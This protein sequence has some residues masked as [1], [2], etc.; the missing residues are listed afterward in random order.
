MSFIAAF[1]AEAEAEAAAPSNRRTSKDGIDPEKMR[2]MRDDKLLQI[3]KSRRNDKAMVQRR[4]VE[5]DSEEGV[6]GVDDAGMQQDKQHQKGRVVGGITISNGAISSQIRELPM[7]TADLMS[8]QIEL[9][10]IGIVYF[11]KILSIPKNPP[12]DLVIQAGAVPRIISFLDL[13]VDPELQFEATWCVTNIACGE[14]RH[15]LNL[16]Q[17]NLLPAIVNLIVYSDS[18]KV[19]A[20]ALWALSNMSSDLECRDMVVQAGAL[21]PIFWLLNIEQIPNRSTVANQSLDMMQ[22]LSHILCNLC[23]GAKSLPTN[24]LQAITF[25]LSDLLQSPDE[26]VYTTIADTL[27]SMCEK[28]DEYIRVVLEQGILT[29]VHA[30]LNDPKVSEICCRVF[31]AV[32]RS[33]NE[34]YVRLVCSSKFPR[35]F[36]SIVQTISNVDAKARVD[37]VSEICLSIGRLFEVDNKYTSKL[38][39]LNLIDA[40]IA[41]VG[42]NRHDLTLHAGGCLTLII[43]HTDSDEILHRCTHALGALAAL[44][45][46]ETSLDLLGMAFVSTRKLVTFLLRQGCTMDPNTHAFILQQMNLLLNH[47]NS[48]ISAL[49]ETVVRMVEGVDEEVV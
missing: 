34:L 36:E 46:P 4:R 39:N 17:N 43:S 28:G 10:H 38:V 12:V 41:A 20:Q 8:D 16:V 5:P 18:D 33:Q 26:T 44:F 2:R 21:T 40:L 32:I 19:R 13:A 37:G 35:V 9:Q 1:E 29:R 24:V 22:H 25:A 42:K 31:C 3:R 7:R 47:A 49:A 14:P 6:D 27:V 45:T 15:S 23:R 11:R 48:E 30:L